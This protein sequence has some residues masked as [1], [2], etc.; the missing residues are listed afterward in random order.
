M[1]RYFLLLI[2]AGLMSTGFAQKPHYKITGKIQGS[3]GMT[4]ILQTSNAGK[5]VILDTVKVVNGTFTINGGSV[6]YPVV[7]GLATTDMKRQ[8]YFY[9]EN[10]DITITGKIDSLNIAVITGSKTQD[11]L[12]SLTLSLKPLENK[13][14]ILMKE[15]QDA[16]NAKDS[17][18]ISILTNLLNNVMKEAIETEKKFAIN[19]PS[20]FAV[21]AVLGELMN[22]LKASEIESIIK[23]MSPEVAKTQTMQDIKARL[24]S[25]GKVEIGQK[26]PDFTLND[27]QGKKVSLSSKIGSKLLLIDFWAGWCGPC[28]KE[29]PNV[30]RVYNEFHGRGFDIIGVS[31]DQTEAQWK[32]A[33]ADDNLTW[34]QVSDLKYWNSEAAKM[35]LVQSIPA[36]FLLDKDGIIIA[37]DLRGEELYNKV[38]EI[39]G[40]K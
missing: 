1:K 38:R 34:T 26:A 14:K 32:K 23:S 31:L 22:S 21:P 37:R 15:Y 16:N 28:R 7:A 18:R 5:V 2:F 36:N 11:E 12:Q 27:P 17:P 39:I 30:V 35:Y 9:L 19:N 4:F 25:V 6:D 24:L 10:N 33:I 3:D 40:K 8:L 29:N 20:S 13:Y